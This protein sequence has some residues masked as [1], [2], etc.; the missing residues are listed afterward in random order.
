MPDYISLPYIYRITTPSGVSYD[1]E[2]PTLSGAWRINYE[3]GKTELYFEQLTAS[4]TWTKQ[5]TLSGSNMAVGNPTSGGDAVSKIYREQYPNT[6]L[7]RGQEN[8][9]TDDVTTYVKMD[10]DYVYGPEYQ[11]GKIE[12]MADTPA[13]SPDPQR[14]EPQIKV[15]STL[16]TIGSGTNIQFSNPEGSLGGVIYDVNNS[17]PLASTAEAGNIVPSETV[18]S[19]AIL[20]TSGVLQT[21]ITEGFLAL[22]A[23]QIT[24]VTDTGTYIKVYDDQDEP[25]RHYHDFYLD[26]IKVAHFT[27]S[28]LVL[29]SGIQF[30][31][32]DDVI[33]DLVDDGTDFGSILTA[34][35]TY[36]GDTITVTVDDASTVF[37]SVLAQG[38]DFNYDRAD[39]DAAATAPAYVMATDAGA[40]DQAVVIRGQ[41]C[42][43]AW[44][45]SAGKLYLSTTIG[46]M[47]QTIPSGTGDQI[48]VLGW[49]L[50][51]DTIFFDPDLTVI[52]VA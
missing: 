7:T 43:T 23:D 36:L 52:E 48:Q 4:G 21:A 25:P 6:Y 3:I 2:F 42:D 32:G 17:Y 34:D 22:D 47:T 13:A 20:T 16:V 18:V 41:V 35:N 29:A 37:G 44:N 33:E 12:L 38:A 27:T 49:A 19:T 15:T 24:S 9:E 30:Q 14:T 5:I 39:A 40:G 1:D 46:E 51:A 26:D 11:N 10:E 31:M 28:A 45:W 8:F 50:S